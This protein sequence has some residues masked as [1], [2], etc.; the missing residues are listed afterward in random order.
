MGFA[1]GSW[2]VQKEALQGFGKG[3]FCKGF[4]VCIFGSFGKELWFI[5]Q[6]L[7]YIYIYNIMCVCIYIYIIIL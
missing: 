2:R 1:V 6:G 7:I 5:F 3:D 4:G